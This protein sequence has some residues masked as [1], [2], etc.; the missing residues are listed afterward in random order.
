MKNLFPRVFAVFLA[1][2]AC[3]GCFFSGAAVFRAKPTPDAWVDSTGTNY[4]ELTQDATPAIQLGVSNYVGITTNI[5]LYGG[6][7][8]QLRFIVVK[9]LVTGVSAY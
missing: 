3:L 7:T 9:G 8:N 1:I 6:S 5:S 4:F 2:V